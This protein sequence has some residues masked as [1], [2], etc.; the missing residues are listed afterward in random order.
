M[1]SRQTMGRASS[2]LLASQLPS[3]FSRSAE[4]SVPQLFLITDGGSGGGGLRPLLTSPTQ[5]PRSRKPY[6]LASQPAASIPICSTAGTA[7]TAGDGQEW[8]CG[9]SHV[10]MTSTTTASFIKY[11]FLCTHTRPHVLNGVATWGTCHELVLMS[12]LY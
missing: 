8:K 1:R 2:L 5:L 12:V 10:C 11:G 9:M 3:A 4:L 6:F 7:G